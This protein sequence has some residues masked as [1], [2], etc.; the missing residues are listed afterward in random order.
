MPRYLL[1][2]RSAPSTEPRDPPSPAQ[3]QEMYAAFTAWKDK[4]KDAIIDMGGKLRPGGKL[5]T[6]GTVSDGPF[7]ETKEII[8]GYMIVEADSYDLAVVIAQEGPGAM[9]PGSSIEIR[10]LAG[11]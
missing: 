10:E 5:V 4:F 9:M 11:P 8:G 6:A 2:Q 3:M 7:V 1:I